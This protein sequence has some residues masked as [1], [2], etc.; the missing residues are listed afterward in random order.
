MTNRPDTYRS[1][2]DLPSRYAAPDPNATRERAIKRLGLLLLGAALVVIVL[3][4]WWVYRVSSAPTLPQAASAIG[5][6]PEVIQGALDQAREHI[7]R[8][9]WPEAIAILEPAV[10]SW[11]DNQ[12]VRVA[13]ARALVGRGRVNSAY[14]Q[15][16]AALSL[17]D[18]PHDL[19]FFAGTVAS[20]AKKPQRALEHFSAAQAGDPN[21]PQYPLYLAQVQRKLGQVDAANV[22]L[23]RVV[24]MDP[25]SAIA[26]G[27]LA[28]IA[29]SRNYVDSALQHIATAR[30]LQP[31]QPAWRIIEARAL[32]RA[33]KPEKALLTLAPLS[34]QDRRA[35]PVL[36]V[37]AECFGLLGRPADAAAIYEDALNASPRDPTLAYEAALWNDRAGN[38]KAAL[39]LAQRAQQLGSQD[40]NAL[41]TRLANANAEEGG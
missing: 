5:P 31:S 7:S 18:R 3:G 36:R 10:R 40:A 17:G 27:S 23:L 2:D 32:K 12:Q 41:A 9:E 11:P 8:A 4:L 16:V 38:T 24:Q 14:E 37:K 29:L 39:D 35:A 21:N 19:E 20:A 26:W 1:V 22:S 28:D 13:Y 30:Q 6:G 15:L 34:E 25:E 33:G